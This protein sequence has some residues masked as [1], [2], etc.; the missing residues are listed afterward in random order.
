MSTAMRCLTSLREPSE[1]VRRDCV[2]SRA[3]HAHG[4][5]ESDASVAGRGDGAFDAFV[6]SAKQCLTMRTAMRTKT[7]LI[8]K[9]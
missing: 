6:S 3:T 5:G 7:I 1:A 4:S 2:V 9:I 8:F